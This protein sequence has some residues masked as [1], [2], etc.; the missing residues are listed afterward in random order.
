MSVSRFSFF[1]SATRPYQC[2]VHPP[3]THL[4][5]FNSLSVCCLTSLSLRFSRARARDSL[6]LALPPSLSLSLRSLSLPPSLIVWFPCYHDDDV[7]VHETQ[8]IRHG[9]G[10]R[11]GC[12]LLPLTA[13]GAPLSRPAGRQSLA[14][15]HVHLCW[16]RCQSAGVELDSKTFFCPYFKLIYAAKLKG[17]IVSRRASDSQCVEQTK[18]L[19][20]LA[21]VAADHSAAWRRRNADG[22][23]RT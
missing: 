12:D 9:A 6:S 18:T 4:S 13:C 16:P 7:V 11:A 23:F 3:S 2:I 8:Q 22:I 21:G 14:A 20:K 5:V 17:Y 19:P 15:C 1:E 10:A